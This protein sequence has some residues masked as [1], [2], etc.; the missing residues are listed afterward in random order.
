[1]DDVEEGSDQEM[2]LL[3]VA[4][5]CLRAEKK[6][7]RKLEDKP[8]ESRKRSRII[9]PRDSE[10][11]DEIQII[12][13][14]TVESKPCSTKPQR[15]LKV[16]A[17]ADLYDLFN[18]DFDLPEI[19]D[20][21]VAE[22]PSK[23][24]TSMLG[25]STNPS[26]SKPGTSTNRSSSKP[27]SQTTWKP[28]NLT[29]DSTSKPGVSLHRYSTTKTKPAAVQQPKT[30]DLNQLLDDDFDFSTIDTVEIPNDFVETKKTGRASP[31]SKVSFYDEAYFLAKGFKRCCTSYNPGTTRGY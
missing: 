4:E 6:D 9:R 14:K 23:P 30:D 29:N 18:D 31:I 22:N 10:S 13:T 21:V 5:A 20:L 15:D 26:V 8:Q 24:S 3:E 25:G 16:E 7:R 12:E 2:S 1:M 17:A 27:G 19:N 28:G 11:D